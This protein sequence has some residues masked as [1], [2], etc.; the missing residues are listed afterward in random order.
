MKT[1][2]FALTLFF[3]AFLFSLNFG[4]T[5][6]N[7]QQIDSLVHQSVSEL[8][9]G[10]NIENNYTLNFIAPESYS[11]LRTS[12]S[13][14]LKGKGI[15]LLKTNSGEDIINYTLTEAKISYAE[16]YK[17]GFFGEYLV[18]RNSELHGSFS[19][20]DE[21]NVGD[22]ILFKNAIIDTVLYS[23]LN[24]LENIAY[25]FASSNIPEEPFFSSSL[26]PAIAIGA[27]AVAVYLFFNIRS[28]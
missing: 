12:V 22:E 16:L 8:S 4:Q 25:P 11:V 14:F 26:E 18:K 21:N 24:N 1:N 20:S 3:S 9:K 28:K 5:K 17:D 6:T 10:L 2:Y 19:I 7:F 15:I 13:K 23:E 27:A